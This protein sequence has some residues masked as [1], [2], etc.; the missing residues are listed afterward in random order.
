MPP[1]KP[2]QHEVERLTAVYAPALARRHEQA[3][4]ARAWYAASM[5]KVRRALRNQ[6]MGVL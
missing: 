1:P 2:T 5:R 4:T 6:R 3:A